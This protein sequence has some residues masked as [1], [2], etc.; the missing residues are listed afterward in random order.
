MPPVSEERAPYIERR[1]DYPNLLAALI[2]LKHEQ[3]QQ[4]TLLQAHIRET[5]EL[6]ELWIGSRWFLNT[7]KFLAITAST[8]A[9][10][11]L[12]LRH[13]GKD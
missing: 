5:Q 1:Q 6:T 10:G 2:E 7:L 9:A 4:R 8:F 12:A 11:Y 13:L 3:E